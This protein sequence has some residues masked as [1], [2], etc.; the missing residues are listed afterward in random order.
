MT[1]SVAKEITDFEANLLASG[2]SLAST[3]NQF[4]RKYLSWP[5]QVHSG[6]AIDAD[7][8]A[9][10]QFPTLIYTATA[11][12]AVIEP[13]TISADSLASVI[14]AVEKLDADTLKSAYQK[15]AVAKSLRKTTNPPSPYLN[16]TLGVLFARESELPIEKIGE[17]LHQLNQRHPSYLWVDCVV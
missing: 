15:I 5:F 7:G 11:N 17:H 2:T 12:D 10:G 3:L 13:T 9:S 4:L 6:N 1:S 8:V 16:T 14:E